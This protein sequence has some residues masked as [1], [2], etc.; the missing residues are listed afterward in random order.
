MCE[1]ELLGSV[2]LLD[3]REYELCEAHE[4]RARLA[5]EGLREMMGSVREARQDQASEQL[6]RELAKPRNIRQ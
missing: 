2:D 5:E 6:I 3:G 1:K 4:Q